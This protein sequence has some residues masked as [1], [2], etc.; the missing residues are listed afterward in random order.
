MSSS[1][2]RMGSQRGAPASAVVSSVRCWGKGGGFCL[3]GLLFHNA[4]G[5]GGKV[6][7]PASSICSSIRSLL[8]NAAVHLPGCTLAAHAHGCLP[9]H[10]IPTPSA[11]HL[12]G[13]TLAT[14][15]H[16]CLPPHPIPTPSVVLVQVGE[17]GVTQSVWGR[18]WVLGRSRGGGGGRGVR[19][20]FP[21]RTA[22]LWGTHLNPSDFR[23]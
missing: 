4:M 2:T 9:P 13:C 11:V 1:P 6:W 5:Q 21:M 19:N 16:G 14:H 23:S 3:L 18:G 17:G 8:P 15:A 7:V 20:R 22:I 12:P 10:P